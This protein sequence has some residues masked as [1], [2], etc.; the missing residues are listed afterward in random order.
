R[1]RTRAQPR[2]QNAE[3]AVVQRGVAPPQKPPALALAEL[4]HDEPLVD[5]GTCRPPVADGGGVGGAARGPVALRVARLDHAVRPLRNVCLENVPAQL[6]QV[7]LHLALVED[8]EHVG[9]LERLDRLES[10]LVGVARSDADDMNLSHAP[11]LPYAL[12][13]P[14]TPLS[15]PG[16]GLLAAQPRSPCP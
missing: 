11:S 12:G 3:R 6:D 1:P 15:Q 9:G 2:L 13:T 16:L 4:L 10:Q 14:R 8:E 5:P 7:R